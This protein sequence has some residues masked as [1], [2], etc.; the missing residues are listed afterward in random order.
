MVIQNM[1]M[2]DP[3]AFSGNTTVNWK[4]HSSFSRSVFLLPSEENTEANYWRSAFQ[5]TST[6]FGSRYDSSIF[7]GYHLGLKTPAQEKKDA[8][9]ILVFSLWFPSSKEVWVLSGLRGVSQQQ[10]T[11]S[12]S[13]AAPMST[14]CPNHWCHLLHRRCPSAVLAQNSPRERLSLLLC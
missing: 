2:P 1:V 10:E 11:W 12:C 14:E 4:S 9:K 7:T 3:S 6:K 13:Q 5:F 8:E